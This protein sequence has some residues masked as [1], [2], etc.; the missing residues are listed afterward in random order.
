MQNRLIHIVS[1]TLALTL[2]SAMAFAGDASKFPIQTLYDTVTAG[3][4]D[5]ATEYLTED[6]LYVLVPAPGPWEAPALVGREAIS[7]G[8]KGMQ[9][10][11][12][13]FEVV[14]L[15]TD[16]DR[17]TFTGLYYGDR[18]EKIEM[19]PAEFDGLAIS[20]DGKILVLLLSYTA[21]YGP[22]LRAAMKN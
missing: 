14:D 13:R 16:G 9:K 17:A 20:R 1:A 4:T 6:A 21:D 12:G 2:S 8:W 5:A 19:S 18:L 11:N 10:D 3:D 15:K 22:K 7:A